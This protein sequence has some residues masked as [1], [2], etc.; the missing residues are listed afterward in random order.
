VGLSSS[1]ELV[2][3]ARAQHID[4]PLEALT[5]L[6]AGAIAQDLPSQDV[7]IVTVSAAAGPV[8]LKWTVSAFMPMTVA[9][10]PQIGEDDLRKL[11][12]PNVNTMTW[13]GRVF[14]LNLD[15]PLHL[16]DRFDPA[17]KFDRVVYLTDGIPVVLPP[18]LES[19]INPNSLGSAAP[20]FS[21]LVSSVVTQPALT[22]AF[23]WSILATF[24]SPFAVH[25]MPDSTDISGSTAAAVEARLFRDACILT[26]DLEAI[27]AAWASFGGPPAAFV[28]VVGAT[29]KERA[30]RWGR[31][32]TNRR[33][34]V[35][36]SG[37]GASA[38]RARALFQAL[39]GAQIPVDV[40]SGLS[41]GAL[42]GSFYAHAGFNGLDTVEAMGPLLQ[43]ALPVV[44]L[45]SWPVELAIYLGLGTAR[46]EDDEVRFVPVT[47]ELPPFG[48][49]ES[50]VV[51]EATI[52][53]A[54]RASGCL[55]PAFAPMVKHGKRYTDGGAAAI[56]PARIA[57]YSGADLSL[58]CNVI[59]GGSQSNPL[60]VIPVVGKLL[61][62][63][64]PL[65]RLIDIWTWYTFMWRQASRRFGEEADVFLEFTPEQIPFVEC[66]FWVLASVIA[67]R[68]KNDP[69]LAP[70][71]ADM[72]T[73]W[74]KLQ[75]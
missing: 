65:G 19:L 60:D 55:P 8:A 48:A 30:Q 38:Y 64:T 25:H 37:G 27:A 17:M 15:D 29:D 5:H 4:A 9:W 20:Y 7:V 14:V 11:I 68:G 28:N 67:N 42:V 47:T 22:A 72:Q 12:A 34:G 44:L 51:V 45:N 62:D 33:V 57:R 50:S 32:A 3:I 10:P 41:G 46:I 40:V 43:V 24:T 13:R 63:W 66:F 49:P 1:P 2:W 52:G 73:K 21:A 75:Q 35:A 71:V 53:Q 6:L 74:A 59:P 69:N 61:H 56:V 26:F 70:R 16:P 54:V 31:A 18:L 39:D 58:A 23:P 36:L